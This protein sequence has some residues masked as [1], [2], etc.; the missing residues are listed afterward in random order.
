MLILELCNLIKRDLFLLYCEGIC[1]V[2]ADCK[3]LRFELRIYNLHH[4]PRFMEDSGTK[5]LSTCHGIAMCKDT[6]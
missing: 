1:F 6:H 2:H 3:G 4:L 5:Q